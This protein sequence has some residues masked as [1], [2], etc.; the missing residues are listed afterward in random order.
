MT[1]K[2]SLQVSIATVH[3][4]LSECTVTSQGCTVV[5]GQRGVTDIAGTHSGWCLA[6]ADT[7]LLTKTRYYTLDTMLEIRAR[8]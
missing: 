5:S 7:L 3:S 6:R 2:G 8:K 4:G 1:I